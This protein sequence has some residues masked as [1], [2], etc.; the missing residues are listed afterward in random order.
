MF[1]V[2]KLSHADLR[3]FR[4]AEHFSFA[5]GGQF[6]V[7][8]IPKGLAPLYGGNNPTGAVGFLRLKLD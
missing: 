3:D 5:I 6:A 1:R 7:N 8:V 2:A 4:I